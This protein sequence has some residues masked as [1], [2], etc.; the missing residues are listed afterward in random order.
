ML[1]HSVPTPTPTIRVGVEVGLATDKADGRTTK[2]SNKTE[3]KI[4][5]L[6]LC[7]DYYN[8]FWA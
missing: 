6:F 2:T 1:L 7:T 3:A 4:D 5:G 8:I